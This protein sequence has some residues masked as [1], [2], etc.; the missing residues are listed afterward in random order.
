MPDNVGTW[1]QLCL[2]VRQTLRLPRISLKQ[3]KVHWMIYRILGG[4]LVH[5]AKSRALEKHHSNV[6]VGVGSAV[7][8]T[9]NPAPIA[10]AVVLSNNQLVDPTNPSPAMH[11]S[12]D[13]W[14]TDALQRQ[15]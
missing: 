3:R 7:G 6:G 4:Q 15:H 14:R 5:R 1:N 2:V 8:Q 11:L 9:S 10:S 12:E 13:F